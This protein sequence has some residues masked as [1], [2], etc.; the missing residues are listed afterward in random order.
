[1][2]T[3]H[4]I[5]WGTVMSTPAIAVETRRP[6]AAKE[7]P[8]AVGPHPVVLG[9]GSAL[10]LWS[11]FP[12]ADWGW[13]VW[14]ALVPLFLM[15]QSKRSKLS[16]YAGSWIGGIVYWTLAVQWIRLTDPSAWL[17]W[18][19]MA[20]AL[21]L[22]WPVF[23][24]LARVAVFQARLPLMIAAPVVWVALE[25]VRAHI[26]SGFPW[27]YLAHT[28][29]ATLPM[30][31]VADLTG[32]LGVS[33][34]IAL[35]NAWWV[36]LVSLPL[37]RPTA[38][39]PRLTPAQSRRIVIVGVLLAGTLGYGAFRLATSRFRDGPRVALL[40]SNLIQQIGGRDTAEN[41]LARFRVLIE[42][43]MAKSPKP[44]LLVWPETSFPYSY[45]VIDKAVEDLALA[46]QLKRISPNLKVEFWRSRTQDV[47]TLLHSW[48][49]SLGVPMVV[50]TSFYDHR[51]TGLAKYNSAVLF[52]PGHGSVQS[53]HKLHLVP[54]GEYIPLI[55]TCPWLTILTPFHGPDAVVPSLNFGEHPTVLR[56][57]PYR[58][59]TAICFEDTVPHVVRRFFHN[60]PDGHPPDILLN[61]SNDG[62][63]KD[64]W[65][66]ETH[67]AVSVFRAVEN[68][69]P[70]A[71]AAN[72]GVSAIVDGNGRVIERLRSLQ[73]GIVAGVLPL[74]DRGSL[75]ARWGDWFGLGCLAITIGMVP[76]GVAR[77]RIDRRRAIT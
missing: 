18:L 68:R 5:I 52:E 3:G 53:Y 1:M 71:R 47:S 7:T 48:P 54:F 6:E 41:I 60:P 8:R 40:Q 31:Q 11:T 44:D 70:L 29:H 49:D 39:G 27:Y 63:F 17:A 23:L 2:T 61:L 28:Q 21:S 38:K 72:T 26:V 66:Q 67:L 62:W 16:L 57:G 65:E 64:S 74:D 24:L 9:I 22:F 32:T 10:V 34:L 50:G 75:Y 30:I 13:L 69:V 59:A 20:L 77:A 33:F 4:E 73:E 12:P 42:R 15:V 37:F 76:L 55:E 14:I 43:A 46:K 36:D 56:L 19:A 45:T 35:V 58:I 25:Y 51:A